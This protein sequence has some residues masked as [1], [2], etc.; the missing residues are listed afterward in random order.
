VGNVFGLQRV[1]ANQNGNLFGFQRSEA[2]VR[3]SKS[4]NRFGLQPVGAKNGKSFK[5]PQN[6]LK[7]H[8]WGYMH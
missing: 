6:L 5:A 2:I 7:A 1:G 4:E 3:L 8:V